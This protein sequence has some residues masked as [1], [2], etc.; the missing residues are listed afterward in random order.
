MCVLQV[1]PW[2]SMDED[3]GKHSQRRSSQEGGDTGSDREF[4]VPGLD[5][6]GRTGY[7]TRVYP[8]PPSLHMR[9]RWPFALGGSW[10]RVWFGQ[11][12]CW[13]SPRPYVGL[14]LLR[15]DCRCCPCVG[16]TRRYNS[17]PQFDGAGN[18][19]GFMHNLGPANVKRP[20]RK[21]KPAVAKPEVPGGGAGPS[22]PA[23]GTAG[24]GRAGRGGGGGGASHH[25]KVPVMGTLWRV[26]WRQLS[27]F[28]NVDL[29]P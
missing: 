18:P 4:L 13:H 5:W 1:N 28:P 27:C 9:A 11:Y 3:E 10:D 15:L 23:P 21:R 25:K 2:S 6:H 12:S 24:A 19:P 20:P 7:V 16:F 22:G 17:L 26:S 8:R 14:G 29:V